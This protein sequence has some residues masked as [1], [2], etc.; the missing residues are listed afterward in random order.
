MHSARRFIIM[1]EEKPYFILRTILKKN[2]LII[3][4]GIVIIT[5]LSWWYSVIMAL[6]I[7][8]V[9]ITICA[10]L[11]TSWS[12]ADF[13]FV[14]LMWVIMMIGMMIPTAAPMILMYSH[15]KFKKKRHTI[16][17]ST[18]AFLSGYLVA[19][20]LF[21]GIA[22][23]L[24][25]FL[26]RHALLSSEL[27][28]TSN[29]FGGILLVTTGIFQWTPLKQA[30]LKNCRSPL[31]FMLTKWKEG[32]TGAFRM[33]FEH[34]AFCVGCCWFLMLLLFVTGVMNIFWGVIIT[35]FVLIEKVAPFGDKI[36]KLAGIP[37]VFSGGYLI[38]I[39]ML[40]SF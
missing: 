39:Y 6:D 35:L 32:L 10:P 22:A 29:L 11:S 36:G 34:G 25:G 26:Q 17:Y 8:E 16:F 21:S 37:L 20:V 28:S 4:S 31:G 12:L 2:Q 40:I 13:S 15:I 1:T 9:G 38:Y 33:G 23:G 7:N 18:T 19:W 14:F 5:L 3:F 27:A 24:Q 30:C